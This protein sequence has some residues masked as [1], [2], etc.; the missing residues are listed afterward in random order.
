MTNSNYFAKLRRFLLG[1]RGRSRTRRRDRARMTT[2]ARP[3]SLFSLEPLES[4]ILLAADLTGGIQSAALLDPAVPTN[5]ASA[6]VRVQNSGNAAVTQ[7]QIGVYASLDNVLDGS[8]LLLGTANTDRVNAG[9]TK[10]ITVNLTLPNTLQPVDYTLLAKVD[11]ANAIA[12]NSE[13]NNVAIGGTVNGTWQ[14]GT[15]PGR[16]GNAVLTLREAD[17][18]VVT[19]S[20]TGPGLGEVIKDGTNWDLKLTGTTASSAVTITTNSAGN[21]RVTLND[22][23]V[24]GPLAALTAATTDLTGTLAIDGP[25]KISGALPGAITLRSVQ[26]GTVAV[27]SVE[28]LTI[29]VSTTNANF[30]IGTTLGQDGQPGGTGANADTYGQGRIGLFTVTGSMTNTSVRVGVDPVD[31][32]Y[33][34]GNDRLIGGTNSSIGKII[35]GGSLSADTRFYAGKFPTQYLHGLTLK[36][37]AGDPHFIILGNA[38]Q[39]PVLAPIGNRA[40]NEGTALTFTATANDPDAG[41]TLTFTLEHGASGHIPTGANI[42]STTGEFTWT[43]TEAQGPGIYT[44][45]VVVTDNGTTSLSD[46]ETITVTVNEVNHAPT[47][48]TIPNQT[49]TVGQVFTFTAV[50]ADTDLPSNTLTYSLEGNFS[51][52]ATI[53]PTT[54]VFTWAPTAVQVGG[55]HGFLVRVTDN[56]TPNRFAEQN[57]QVTVEPKPNQ[58]PVLN[59]I[60]N[61]TVD[62]GQQLRFFANATDPDGSTTF[63]FTIEAEDGGH[64]PD[65]AIMDPVGGFAWT[66]TEAQGPG[67]YTFDVV[68]TDTTDNGTPALSDRETIT[69]TVN[70]VPQAPSLAP[71]AEQTVEAGQL[72]TFTAVGTDLDIPASELTYSLQ[73][74]VPAGT[75]ID[76]TTG[77]FTWTPTAAQV[78]PQSVTIRV[79]DNDAALGLF[80]QQVVL[81][82]VNGLADADLDGI[83]DADEG[84]GPNGGDANN[85]GIADSQQANVASFRN[86]VD[87]HY[88]TLVSPT[89]TQLTNVT[90]GPIAPDAPA[91][92]EFPFG[93]IGFEVHGV[94]PGGSTEL[95]MLL[96]DGSGVNSFYKFGPEPGVPPL[97]QPHWY[98]FSPNGG[99]GATI[100]GNTV[101]LNFIDGARGDADLTANGVIV[102]P[103]AP[104]IAVNNAPVLTAIGNK[105]VNE[106]ATLSFTATAT[107]LDGA[108]QQLSFS[109]VGNLPQGATINS[110]TGLFTYMPGIDVGPASFVFDVV[111][112]DNGTPALSDHESIRVTVEESSPVF[113]QSLQLRNDFRGV[114]EAVSDDGS[115]VVVRRSSGADSYRWTAEAGAQILGRLPNSDNVSFVFGIS[116]NGAIA[117]G[118]QSSTDGP[119]A[120]RWSSDGVPLSL[121]SGFAHAASVD[122]SVVVGMRQILDVSQAFRW[123]QGSG[124]VGLGDL[125]GGAFASSASDVSADGS[126]VVGVGNS[127]AGSEAF[128]WTSSTDFLTLGDLPGGA[129]SSAANA[130]SA[131]GLVVVGDSISSLGR[132]AFR[133]TADTGMIP[134]G[135]IPSSS[136]SSFSVAL[137]VSA[138]GA[139]IVGRG[140][141]TNSDGNAFIWDVA[142]GMR[143]LQ[144]VLVADYGRGAELA[145]WTLVEATE[146]SADGRTIVGSGINPAGQAQGWRIV[147]P[148]Q[149]PPSLAPIASQVVAENFPLTVTVTATD[150]DPGQILTYSLV[151]APAGATINSATGVFTW[152]P[153]E[154]QGPGSYTFDVIV[155][156]SGIPRLSDR[157]TVTITVTDFNQPPVLG[158]I[159][160]QSVVE[161][162]LLT[163]QATASDLDIPLNALSFTLSGAVPNG[164]TINENTGVFSWTPGPTQSGVYTFDVI[165]TDNGSPSLSD[166]ETITVTVADAGMGSVSFQGIGDLTGGGF[167]SEVSGISAD[168]SV[169]VGSSESTPF[170]LTAVRWTST[171]GL[172]SLGTLPSGT[173]RGVARAASGDGSVIVGNALNG[174]NQNE[175]FRWTAATGMVGLGDLPGGFFES[176]ANDVSEDGE[177]VVGQGISGDA[178]S[179]RYQAFR[180]T[181][182]GGIVGLGFL[183]GSGIL[184]STAEA[185]ND[186][187]SVVVGYSTHAFQEAFRWTAATGMVGLGRLSGGT[188]SHA[189]NV[190]SDG[191]VIVG[192]A[193]NGDGFDEAFRWSQS[194]GMIGLGYLPGGDSQSIARAVSSDGRVVVGLAGQLDGGA[195]AFVWD[196]AHGMRNLQDVL[197]NNFGMSALLTGWTLTDAVALSAD[198]RVIAGLGINPSGDREG[199]RVELPISL[200]SDPSHTAPYLR[201]IG[202]QTV[203]AGEPL[204]LTTTAEDLDFPVQSLTFSLQGAPAGASIDPATGVFTWTPT[205]A[206]APATYTFDMVVTDSDP[207]AMSDRET[208]TITV[209]MPNRAPVLDPIGDRTIG[210]GQTLSFTADVTDAD[211][212]QT[213]TFALE[214]GTAGEVPVGGTILN[215]GRFIW[216]PTEEQG[217]GTYTFDIV[218]TDSGDPVLS[219]RE[220][221]TVIV[222]EAN[223][224]PVLNAIGNLTVTEG[225]PLAFTASATDP[226][227]PANTWTFSLEDGVGGLVPVGATINPTTGVFTWI[228]TEAQGLG[229]STFDVIVTDNGSPAL[230]D[231]ETIVVT[232]EE[233]NQA[234]VLDEIGAKTV[235]ASQPLTFTA[236][237]SDSDDPANTLQFSLLNEPAG[238][239][240]DPN[241]GVFTWTPTAGQAGSHAVT[242]RVTDNGTPALF[243]EK[244]IQITV[245]AAANSAPVLN[246]IANQTGT[247][248]QPVQFTASATD[249]ESPPQTLTYSLE[250]G[251]GQV[252][253]GATI[254]ASTGAFSWTPSAAGTVT[255][256]VVVR[257]NGTPILEDRQSVQ[258]TVNPASGNQA[259][260]IVSPTDGQIFGGFTVGNPVSIPPIRATDPDLPSETLT[261]GLQSPAGV[262]GAQLIQLDPATRRFIWTPTSAGSFRFV[263]TVTDS[264][265]NSDSCEFFI[266]VT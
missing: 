87:N 70:E 64:V 22:I 159:G 81:I 193:T 153:T 45:D 204:T 229:T 123:T 226:D 173:E 110:T 83:P 218:V 260:T 90:A 212:G 85:D 144:Q 243:D 52:G 208:I 127:A 21:G 10:N 27:P 234:P 190:S 149:N 160:N 132:E 16:T 211:V 186:D 217:P 109:L 225:E 59:A 258:I 15:V 121:G 96:P 75:A 130:V 115:V 89:G 145:G 50:G 24:F 195:S 247:A 93:Q 57:V 207:L 177:V 261:W 199:W 142:H 250:N 97:D 120:I 11:N 176:L 122:G 252:P 221:I 150:P 180:W 135:F 216:T 219:D 201:A 69:V 253:T 119:E 237:A 65:G 235:T 171:G 137:D 56:G 17:G 76:P 49:A 40:A 183:P 112:T 248:G 241:S 197:V 254:N 33:G 9:Q 168:G 242:V 30:Y 233:V 191:K 77:V 3:S 53:D 5:T 220:T 179:S 103:G 146:I 105:T 240:I 151:N 111:V 245:N 48:A 78:G 125:P 174:S 116:G 117:V 80:A 92:I 223:Q 128:R 256:D 239:S 182:S 231:S 169:V 124:M 172:V 141:S 61:Q 196:P 106:G 108:S 158:L 249:P 138:D 101:T 255:F 184:R 133:W 99:T 222:T 140:R 265:G 104:A 143:E 188:S 107:D 34:N 162:N 2:A 131:D 210:D 38:N 157:E 68:V 13:T 232:V 187:G 63:R 28:A 88:V 55:P 102:D 94:T 29:L 203:T 163:F 82:T 129:F 95:M 198:G 155:T 238:A 148:P 194:A 36:P 215:T 228:P 147:L 230:S 86:A 51:T 136:F 25:V 6:V 26:G 227:L 200:G 263:V 175:A 156:D 62:E 266:N 205:L 73:G 42:N 8:D 264:A 139:I 161:G 71:I 84:A 259:P 251:A 244:T 74:T 189:V 23:H 32:L 44:F 35:I 165:V 7:S 19:F 214:N 192:F 46:R 181:D 67:T 54:G 166:R 1:E 209:N 41:Q 206:Q 134:L 58:A 126:V 72:L 213:H 164:A 4:R 39:P 18:T 202:N 31:G 257:D 118:F 152:A 100:S 20:L 12:E 43:P 14:F 66:P 224:V 262:V 154:A 91:G 47:L 37:T 114:A 98:D 178:E 79:T 236:S 170:Q 113:F 246:A 60:G 185:A 167:A